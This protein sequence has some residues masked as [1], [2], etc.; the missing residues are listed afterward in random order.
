MFLGFQAPGLGDWGDWTP[1]G[2]ESADPLC[3]LD[4]LIDLV[5]IAM[6]VI[7]SDGLPAWA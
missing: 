6:N 3:Y 2:A 5:E 4:G 1:G 7:Q